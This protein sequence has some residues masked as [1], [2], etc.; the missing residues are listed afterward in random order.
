MVKIILSL[1]GGIFVKKKSGFDRGA[2]NTNKKIEG[3]DYPDFDDC[4][5]LF[6]DGYSDSEIAHELG[7]KEDY[8]KKI[9]EEYLKEY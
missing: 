1:E 2:F 3:A 4:S 8:I 7:V 9:R 5:E 6:Q